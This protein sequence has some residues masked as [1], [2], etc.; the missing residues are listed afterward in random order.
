[1]QYRST[2]AGYKRPPTPDTLITKMCLL[3]ILRMA[4]GWMRASARFRDRCNKTVEI[5][6]DVKSP[7]VTSTNVGKPL[8]CSYKFRSNIR[9][10]NWIIS[11]RLG[12]QKKIFVLTLRFWQT[13]NREDVRSSDL[14]HSEARKEPIGS[15]Q[16]SCD[17]SG[18][19]SKLIT[20]GGTFVRRHLSGA[21]CP[22]GRL[23]E[24]FR[25]IDQSDKRSS[26][27]RRMIC[28]AN[29]HCT[30]DMSQAFDSNYLL[31]AL[32]LRPRPSA[33]IQNKRRTRITAAAIIRIAYMKRNVQM[34][35]HLITWDN[36]L[37]CTELSDELILL[38][39]FKL[40]KC[41]QLL[42]CNSEKYNN[43]V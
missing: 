13:G 40:K 26:D 38:C 42:L 33:V 4:S 17:E 27:K 28:Q 11:V 30:C 36:R 29:D 25:T 34:I 16:P 9:K 15:Q 22:C 1:M 31:A 39:K 2:Y 14:V 21:V 35:E 32:E 43:K 3:F 24:N 5:K 18:F 20:D 6:E 10:T 19:Y 41:E 37:G 23:S 7:P 8:L 12:Q